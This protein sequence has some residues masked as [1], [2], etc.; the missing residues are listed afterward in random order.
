MSCRNLICSDWSECKYFG[1]IEDIFDENII[2]EP[3][4]TS[5]CIC[6]GENIIGKQKC[7]VEELKYIVELAC[8]GRVIRIFDSKS[9]IALADIDLENLR[10]NKLDI[11]FVQNENCNNL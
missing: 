10:K 5:M 11:L 2:L 9:K 4:Q 6:N 8:D 7:D 1:Q 3:I